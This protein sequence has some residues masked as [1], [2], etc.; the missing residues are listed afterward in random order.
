MSIRSYILSIV[1]LL[2]VTFAGSAFL[3]VRFGLPWLGC[4]GVVVVLVTAYPCML[5][6]ALNG[7]Y[8]GLVRNYGFKGEERIFPSLF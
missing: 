3:L 1:F 8:R 5:F 6:A 4:Q 7:F 2:T